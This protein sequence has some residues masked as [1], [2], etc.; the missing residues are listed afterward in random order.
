MT[1]SNIPS[2]RNR[3]NNISIDVTQIDTVSH[4]QFLGMIIDNKINWNE[5][6]KY[7]CKPKKSYVLFKTHQIMSIYQLNKYV[8]CILMY[9]HNREM[10]PNIFNDMFMKHT[11][12]TD[13]IPHYK[14]NTRH[15]TLADAGPRLWN[16]RLYTYKYILKR[17]RNN[18]SGEYINKKHRM[19]NMRKNSIPYLL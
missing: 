1:F 19:I 13:K 17:Q 12:S 18:A 15:T 14:T 11:P 5:H 4:T 10:L 7:T 2:V 6:I 8:T 16:T 9:K 3:I